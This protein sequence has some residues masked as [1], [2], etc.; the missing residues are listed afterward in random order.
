M[1]L[2]MCLFL[3]SVTIA[4]TSAFAAPRG[5]NQGVAKARRSHSTKPEPLVETTCGYSAMLESTLKAI[6]YDHF[7]KLLDSNKKASEIVQAWSD[8]LGSSPSG[9]DYTLQQSLLNLETAI[10]NDT[11]RFREFIEAR[12]TDRSSSSSRSPNC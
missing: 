6:G 3:V 12:L 2:G 7:Q 5:S 1:K 8:A 10:G 9:T 11:I 4:T